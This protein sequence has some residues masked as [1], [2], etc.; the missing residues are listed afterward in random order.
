MKE[1]EM[2]QKGGMREVMM[3]ALP[4]VVSFAC[5]TVMIFT[6]RLFLAQI[7]PLLMNASMG[8]GVTAYMMMTFFLGLTGYSTA[9]AAQYLGSGRKNKAPV[10]TTQAMAVIALGYPVVLL[11]RPAAYAF[12]EHSGISPAQ[13]S[14]QRQY[15]D[16]ITGFCFIP[17]ARHV[18]SSYF[19][20]IGKTRIVM[21]ASL[22]S[23]A[24]N[25]AA[26]YVLIF[27]KFG[28][29][30]MGIRGAAYGTITGAG[31]GL[32]LLAGAY[33]S[34][35]NRNEF[36]VLRSLY[37]DPQ[38]FKSLLR[39]G[40]PP[41]VEMFL[42]IFA[43]DCLIMLLH[44]VGEAAATASTIALNWD[45][46]VYIPLMGIEMG[47]TSLVGRYMGA[48]DIESARRSTRSALKMGWI[49]AFFVFL[50]F[51][52]FARQ[53]VM[54][55]HSPGD[56]HFF[57]N[58][59]P[60]AEFMMRLIVL[61]VWIQAMFVVFIGALRGAGDTLWT[62]CF[63]VAL[64]WIMVPILY[65]MLKVYDA[66]IQTAWVAIISIF[67]GSSLVLLMRYRQGK[68]ERIQVIPGEKEAQVLLQAEDPETIGL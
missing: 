55:F 64:H 3:I 15:F 62:M 35:S 68:W 38:I 32:L 60:L 31:F 19:T 42:N 56:I 57:E 25:V 65:V 28:F 17:L 43:F 46:V 37:F 41:G 7:N 52:F 61:Y 58:V 22:A 40:T 66:S 14:G 21:T 34:A 23:M 12:F 4:M 20:G 5:E 29:P 2:I 16:I 6:D 10:V 30:E 45:M 18:L 26:N 13:L 51:S 27:G 48:R 49:Y 67:M 1:N 44:S 53:L 8:G 9:L 63:S 54:V 50:V 24:V 11:C 33:F 39:Y 59:R 36:G 47:I